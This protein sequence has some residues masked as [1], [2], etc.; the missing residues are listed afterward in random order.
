MC[1][2]NLLSEFPTVSPCGGS[3]TTLPPFADLLIVLPSFPVEENRATLCA[4]LQLLTTQL[5]VTRWLNKLPVIY[6]NLN[7]HTNLSN[8]RRVPKGRQPRRSECR[9]RSRAE[10]S[11]ETE[12]V[13]LQLLFAHEQTEGKSAYRRTTTAP[14]KNGSDRHLREEIDREK[15]SSRAIRRRNPDRQDLRRRSSNPGSGQN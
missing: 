11:S 2:H 14:D 8:P 4:L 3:F 12:S 10:S 6:S 7:V 5:V 15:E 1:Q 13:C 9:R